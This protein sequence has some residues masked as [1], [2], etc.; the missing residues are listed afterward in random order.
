MGQRRLLVVLLIVATG[1]VDLGIA[2]SFMGSSATSSGHS[3]DAHWWFIPFVGL[4]MSQVNLLAALVGWGAIRLPWGLVGVVLTAGYLA[5]LL[6]AFGMRAGVASEMTEGMVFLLANAATA[7]GLASVTRAIGLRMVVTRRKG[8]PIGGAE[9]PRFQFTLGHMFAWITSTAVVLGI[10]RYT[11]HFE[12]IPR[13]GPWRELATI[14][15]TYSAFAIVAGLIMLGLNQ[16]VTRIVFLG[17]VTVLMLPVQQWLS[18][19]PFEPAG[20]ITLPQFVWLLA[21]TLVLRVAGYRLVRRGAIS[22][23][24]ASPPVDSGSG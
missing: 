10:L 13:L 5:V 14:C 24:E 1:L 9:G 17:L 6:L 4:A 7:F 12:A 22:G 23:T 2:A 11:V 20:C 16:L 19:L 15:L 18:D 3:A 8:T 21:A